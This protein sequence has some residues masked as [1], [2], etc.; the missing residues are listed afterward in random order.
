MKPCV[1][2]VSISHDCLCP[3]CLIATASALCNAHHV[4][5]EQTRCPSYTCHQPCLYAADIS[6]LHAGIV[7]EKLN[8]IKVS[9]RLQQQGFSD[10]W[11]IQDMLHETL[12]ALADAQLLLGMMSI[13]KVQAEHQH[14]CH[15]LIASCDAV[16]HSSVS[17]PLTS[18][19]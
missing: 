14:V 16:E 10:I 3:A 13:L 2:L 8:G 15:L 18:Y 5:C 17:C 12:T 11:Y 6:L 7:I 9:E 1:L 19:L 4:P